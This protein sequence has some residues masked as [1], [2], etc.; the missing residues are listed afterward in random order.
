MLQ[1]YFISMG[2]IFVDKITKSLQELFAFVLIP[3]QICIEI[4]LMTLV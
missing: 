4:I 1:F 2:L 3:P